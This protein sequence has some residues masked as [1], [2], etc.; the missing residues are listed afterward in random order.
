[1]FLRRHT[2]RT[3]FL[4]L[5][6]PVAVWGCPARGGE[7]DF[8]RDIRPLLSEHCFACHGPDSEQRQ[9]D[10]RLDT[11]SGAAAVIAGGSRHDSELYRR[12][13]SSDVDEVMPPADAPRRLSG[14]QIELVGR[15][16]DEG[17]KWDTHWSFQPLRRPPVPRPPQ[18]AH[19]PQRNAIDVFVQQKLIASGLQP[20]AE[21]SRDKLLRRLTLDL[22]GLPPT[23]QQ[24]QAFTA[25]DDPLAYSRLVDQ[26]LSS[27]H[28]GQRMA[29]D[30]LDAAR[31]ADSNGYQGDRDRSMWPWRDWVISAFNE[32]MPF[33][34]FTVWQLAGDLLPQATTEQQLA[35]AFLRN[36][37][38]NGEG[39]RIAEE[40]RIEYLF[41]MAETTGTVWLALTMNCC[42]CHDHK[43]DPL[44]NEDYYRLTA[45]FNQTPVTGQGGDPRTPPVLALPSAEQ[46]Q[47]QT[48]L[49]TQ[50]AQQRK[51]LADLSGKYAALP[52]PSGPPTDT[53]PQD[54]QP[55]DT[56]SKDTQ[57]SGEP[58][59]TAAQQTQ[60][61]ADPEYQQASAR[62]E[63]FESQLS[64]LGKQIPQVMVMRDQATPRQSYRLERGL[65]NQP[66]EEVFAGTPG[67]LP[68]G[69][70]KKQDRLALA[71]WIVADDNPLTARVIVNRLWQQLFGMGLV[72]TPEDLGVQGE[73]PPQ[74]ELLD[75]LAAELRDSGW[76][77]KHV[78]RMIV[79]SH[80]YRQS[81]RL[82]S[83]AA[84]LDP[85]NRLLAR[86]ARYR[87][88]SW[89][90]RDQAL[91]VSGL[92]SPVGNGPGVNSYQPAGVWEE[93]TFGKTSY[94]PGS[95]EELYRRSLFIFWRRII[96]P[97]MFFDNASRQTCTVN[98]SRTNTPLHALLT[99]NDVT[100]V[101]A[102]RAL[103]EAVLQQPGGSDAGRLDA[104]LRRVLARP[105]SDSERQILLAGLERTRQQFDDSPDRAEQLLAVGQ[106]P[107]D[108]R[109]NPLEH[110]SWT[111]LCLAVL[112]LDE[113]LCHE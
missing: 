15:W 74:R 42:R 92:L 101:E 81:S 43:F 7:I 58:L 106:S 88:P 27:T 110:A 103:A 100:Y 20:A 23:P 96:A 32:N 70:D 76:D 91:A 64:K 45:Y 56:T 18:L 35:T 41:D 29:W 55:Q 67:F 31:Y 44:T 99:L 37:M 12:L 49:Q 40:N 89:M 75:W 36:H 111:A 71:R 26:L 51:L 97:T 3:V 83:S 6:I 109:L 9:G 62:L 63:R 28:Y 53:Q 34:D 46:Q 33:D 113:T 5:A 61:E 87:L 22:T 108:T 84:E 13:L 94:V 10:L 14:Q 47:R 72:K 104:V 50:I 73:V 48:Q 79:C 102:A 95:G 4:A 25:S 38:I 24:V 69:A 78:L 86:G 21:A 2:A 80:T 82:T 16:L 11:E 77:L 66:R 30:W 112:N 54:T 39:G 90:L 68:R 1:M 65:Y 107:R 59:L 52:P 93:A 98:L 19:A 60:L 57:L 17:A 105:A 8:A 85:D